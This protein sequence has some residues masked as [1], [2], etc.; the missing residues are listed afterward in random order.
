MRLLKVTVSLIKTW[1]KIKTDTRIKKKEYIK[2]KINKLKENF[3][4]YFIN[5][6]NQYKSYVNYLNGVRIKEYLKEIS[7]DYKIEEFVSDNYLNKLKNKVFENEKYKGLIVLTKNVSSLKPAL[8][9]YK[10]ENDYINT[11]DLQCIP[12][13]EETEFID[14]IINLVNTNPPPIK[15]KKRQPAMSRDIAAALVA[16]QLQS[17]EVL[18]KVPPTE[19]KK[20]FENLKQFYGK[21]KDTKLSS[22]PGRYLNIFPSEKSSINDTDFTNILSYYNQPLIYAVSCPKAEYKDTFWEFV[23]NQDIKIIINLT[24]EDEIPDKCTKYYDDDNKKFTKGKWKSEAYKYNRDLDSKGVK[25]YHYTS[26]PD[27]G[28][29]EVSDFIDL[30]DEDLY[31]NKKILIHCSAGVGRT[32]VFLVSYIIKI[33]QMNKIYEEKKLVNEGYA[34][35]VTN[36][37][38]LKYLYEF[39][40]E[41]KYQVTDNLIKRI[42]IFLRTKRSWMVQTKGQFEFIK[43]VFIY[44]KSIDIVKTYNTKSE[45]PITIID[46]TNEINYN[47]LKTENIEPRQIIFRKSSLG[48]YAY[49]FKT[50]D[51]RVKHFRDINLVRENLF[52]P[53]KVGGSRKQRKTKKSTKKQ[54]KHKKTTRKH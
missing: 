34:M 30:L 53:E 14:K 38:E 33:F 28:V 41:E 12:I 11:V 32:G 9:I 37:N 45:K 7:F 15:D 6:D 20:N 21:E 17:A 40:K 52:E 51:N 47:R 18:N 42:I 35:D 54:R 36:L 5:C 1:E 16:S 39:Y 13:L 29:P 24:R 46:K 10:R 22:Y 48:D 4:I 19:Y 26:W 44:D 43:K 2:Y 31:M 23:K 3:D 8:T 27:H 50:N 25:Y 49:T